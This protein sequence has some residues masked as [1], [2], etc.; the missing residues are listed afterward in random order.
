MLPREH[1]SS[2][3]RP[4]HDYAKVIATALLIRASQAS[5]HAEARFTYDLEKVQLKTGTIYTHRPQPHD[6][7]HLSP[8]LCGCTEYRPTDSSS[9][10]NR[11]AIGRL[12]VF[13][14]PGY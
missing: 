9:C 5:D 1:V 10:A 4:P 7:R 12:R 6:I 11:A 2:V 14:L 13:N 8:Y 3:P